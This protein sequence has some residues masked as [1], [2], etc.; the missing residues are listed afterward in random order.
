MKFTQR[1]FFVLGLLVTGFT[2]LKS[3]DAQAVIYQQCHAE[4]ISRDGRV[5]DLFSSTN[6]SRQ[7]ACQRALYSCREDLLQRQRMGR[8]LHAYCEL[9]SVSR[10]VPP[11]RRVVE[12]QCRVDLVQY[13]RRGEIRFIEDFIAIGR[14]VTDQVAYEKACQQAERQCEYARSTSRQIGLDCIRSRSVRSGVVIR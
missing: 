10:P 1:F 4:M 9:R 13:M 12:R 5:I 7:I 8:N 3:T 2:T 6:L 14:A 11:R